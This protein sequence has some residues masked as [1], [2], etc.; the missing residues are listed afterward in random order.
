MFSKYRSHLWLFLAYISPF[1]SVIAL[2]RFFL[3][4]FYFS[5]PTDAVPG[6]FGLGLN[7]LT[8]RPAP[9]FHHPGYFFH[10]LSAFLIKITGLPE[11]SLSAFNTAGIWVQIL[12]LVLTS[13]WMVYL[14]KKLSLNSFALFFI[15]LLTATM[16][17]LML[18]STIWAL[19]YPLCLLAVPAILAIYS[20]VIRQKNNFLSV[21]FPFAVLGFLAGSF[22]LAMFLVVAALIS[23]LITL[24]FKDVIASKERLGMLNFTA[25]AKF[26]LILTLL[27]TMAILSLGFAVAQVILQLSW[28]QPLE[29]IL[30]I[31]IITT[32]SSLIAAVII[33]IVLLKLARKYKLME[34]ILYSLTLPLLVGWAIAANLMMPFW[35]IS[36]V[37]AF[38]FKGGASSSS[39][40]IAFSS[41]SQLQISQFLS[42]SIWHWLLILSAI[43]GLIALG[44]AIKSKSIKTESAFV[45]LFCLIALILNL[46]IAADVTLRP[47]SSEVFNS[48]RFGLLSRYFMMMVSVVAL[49]AAWMFRTAKQKIIIL[50]SVV[51]LFIGIASFAQYQY[52]LSPF[53]NSRN[54]ANNQIKEIVNNYLAEEPDGIVIC[55][56]TVLPEFCS[57]LYGYNNYRPSFSIKKFKKETTRQG[58]IKY[59]ENF[60]E[61]CKL[62]LN[63][64]LNLD[65]S[66]D[67][68]ILVITERSPNQVPPN[69]EIIWQH[70]N[71]DTSVWFIK[72]LD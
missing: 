13:L 40:L 50:S 57:V 23:L 63:Q 72:R 3:K 36:A 71:V 7:W 56:R 32:I 24:N 59:A 11:E 38:L 64:C 61:N 14:A 6:F 62:S 37:K 26:K 22:F 10:Q 25:S 8:L 66:I 33:N 49:S 31:G 51:A 4:R 21:F 41:L 27:I 18:S 55:A 16:P 17:T 5:T 12:F 29:Y 34:L 19:Y 47:H 45:G 48:E 35:G 52:S 42:H 43:V 67:G 39:G 44:Q 69:T 46:I 15:G 30:R 2:D 9:T 54:L 1:I 65:E 68:N 58:R 53:I 60:N 20:I 70:P 28:N